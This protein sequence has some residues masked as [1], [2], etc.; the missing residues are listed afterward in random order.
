MCDILHALQKCQLLM[1]GIIVLFVD[2]DVDM[3]DLLFVK[4]KILAF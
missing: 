4:G 2:V 3:D 1:G